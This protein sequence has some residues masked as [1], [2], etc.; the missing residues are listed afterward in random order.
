MGVGAE[1]AGVERFRLTFSH[2]GSERDVEK[3]FF[4]QVT[5]D[6]YVISSDGKYDNLDTDML[7][8]LTQARGADSYTIWFT[9][10]VQRVADFFSKDGK[11][12]RSYTVYRDRKAVSF[13]NAL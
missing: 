5:A 11:K 1:R 12:G 10:K 13:E 8:M 4:E 2:H 7:K 9:N 6:P 3:R